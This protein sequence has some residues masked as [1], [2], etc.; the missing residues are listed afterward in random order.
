M[1]VKNI[2]SQTLKKWLE[3]DEAVLVDVREPS[4]H[5]AKNIK[6]ANL[7]PLAQICS[8]KLPEIKNKKLVIHCHSGKRSQ[9][10]CEKLLKENEDLEIYN[11]EGGISAFENSGC[12]VNSSGKNFLPLDRQVQLIIGLTVLISSIL[13]IFINVKFAIISAF[14]GAGLAFSGLTGFCGLALLVARCPWN[15]CQKTTS[16]KIS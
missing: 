3:N 11:L 16:C 12:A 13:A 14:F 2:D 6:Q 10:A 4:E 8:A 1:S 5:A 15:K 7:I 9:M